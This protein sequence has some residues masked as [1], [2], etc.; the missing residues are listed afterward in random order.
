MSEVLSGK[1]CLFS[2]TPEPGERAACI[3][4]ALELPYRSAAPGRDSNKGIGAV[5]FNS[6]WDLIL[7]KPHIPV[8]DQM[9][10]E[11]IQW[12]SI[13]QFVDFGSFA[14]SLSNR[15]QYWKRVYIRT[16]EGKKRI[17]ILEIHTS[18]EKL[19]ASYWLEPFRL[20]K[21]I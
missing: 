8:L 10:L 20:I 11:W 19:M 6:T 7:D 17:Q 14:F 4:L 12:S 1:A 15:L 3:R 9:G 13:L 5:G 16:A 18:M 2:N 21:G